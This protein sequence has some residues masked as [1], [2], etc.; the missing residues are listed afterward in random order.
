MKLNM[1]D[2]TYH[3]D[4]GNH[5]GFGTQ[6]EQMK[7]FI[8][9]LREDAKDRT[10]RQRMEY[11]ILGPSEIQVWVLPW[12]E[13]EKDEIYGKDWCNSGRFDEIRRSLKEACCRMRNN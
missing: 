9:G 6:E 4:I 2:Y 11:K 5:A 10:Y 1:E 8:E 3:A 12:P 7:D 13:N